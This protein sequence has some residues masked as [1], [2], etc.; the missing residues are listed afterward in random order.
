M[1]VNNPLQLLTMVANSKCEIHS[2]TDMDKWESQITTRP[3]DNV[4]VSKNQWDLIKQR[5]NARVE[6]FLGIIY[7]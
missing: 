3:G 2:L 5:M 1:A 4:S 7:S 6:G